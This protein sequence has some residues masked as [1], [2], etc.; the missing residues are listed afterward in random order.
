MV[1]REKLRRE[2]ER[3][4]E[5]GRERERETRGDGYTE[6]IILA[7]DGLSRWLP[8]IQASRSLLRR[9]SHKWG[10]STRPQGQGCLLI[11]YSSKATSLIDAEVLRKRFHV[12]R[13]HHSRNMKRN[14]SK[15]P[16]RLNNTAN[17]SAKIVSTVESNH[18]V[19][20]GSFQRPSAR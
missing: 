13:R 10:P 9:T 2:R 18:P 4:R 16:I 17:H 7:R 20:P 6:Q 3:E 1:R 5:G 19:A 15:Q 12:L 14:A 11:H 8:I